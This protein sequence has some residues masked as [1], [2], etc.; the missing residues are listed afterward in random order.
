M[1]QIL[2]LWLICLSLATGS[3]GF[4]QSPALRAARELITNGK[5]DQAVK[6]LRGLI[7]A[8]PADYDARVLLGTTLAIRGIRSEAIEQIAEAA[9]LRPQ[10][11]ETYNLLGTTLSRFMETENARSAF[12]R[13]IQLDP[14]LAEAQVNLALLLAQAGDWEGAG[15]HLDSALAVQGNSPASAY[16]HF[17]RAKIWV[18]Q[19]QFDR[20]SAEL[21]QAVRVRPKY[22]EAWSDLGW[23]RR[24]ISDDKGALQASEK[25]VLL[26]PKDPAAQYRLGTAYLRQG[27]PQRAVQHLRA[28]LRLGGPD[29]PTLYNLEQA[30][31]KAGNMTEAQAIRS[32]MEILLQ[33]NRNSSENALQVAHLNS[34]GMQLEKQ[35]DAQ[36]AMMKY[37]MALELDP[38]AGGIRLNY[39]LSLC[40]LHRWHDGIAEIQEV[41]RVDPDN[42]TAARALYI[43]KEQAAR[44]SRS[45]SRKR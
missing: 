21:E 39:G 44:D 4:A 13:A 1:K 32:Q 40:R 11:A 31:R 34:E 17:L 5:P 35:G 43:A 38:T 37:R 20:A 2:S 3:Q 29:K 14:G 18:V 42:G 22:A 24:M 36:G 16:S 26:N 27:L 23:S 19:S 28:A 45:S 6:I 12:E 8:D 25:A 7:Q 10:S 30:L 9:K 15:E 41:L 33:A